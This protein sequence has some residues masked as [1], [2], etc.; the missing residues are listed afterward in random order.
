MLMS[1]C[2]LGLLTAAPMTAVGRRT[3][4]VDAQPGILSQLGARLTLRDFPGMEKSGCRLGTHL[5]DVCALTPLC[6]FYF[7]SFETCMLKL[8]AGSYRQ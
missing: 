7:F 3:L 4:G 5:G 1:V 8:S 6:C 2:S